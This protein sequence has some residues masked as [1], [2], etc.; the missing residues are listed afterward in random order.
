MF[1]LVQTL[2]FIISVLT[3]DKLVLELV[4]MKDLLTTITTE[5][6]KPTAI[7]PTHSFGPGQDHGTRGTRPADREDH[8][9]ETAAVRELRARQTWMLALVDGWDVTSGSP[10]KLVAIAD[11]ILAANPETP[12]DDPDV[13]SAYSSVSGQNTEAV[14]EYGDYF[15]D[16]SAHFA[17][18]VGM[19][20]G[21]G[22]L[23]LANADVYYQGRDLEGD[24][25]PEF[26]DGFR[27]FTPR[28]PAE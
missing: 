23:R 11:E 6:L 17:E 26:L 22:S 13:P 19:R 2:M 27:I 1:P 7:N 28:M 3:V 9:S 5:K 21:Y 8:G 20:L 10:K 18:E 12:E 15:Y 25:E 4:F 24:A 14:W 16:A